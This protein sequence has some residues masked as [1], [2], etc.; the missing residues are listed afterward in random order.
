MALPRYLETQITKLGVNVKL[1]REFDAAVIE[2]DKPD[3]VILATGGRHEVAEI[4]GINSPNVID[5]AELHRK[6]K[7]Y[8]KLVKPY[9]LRWMT[10]YWMPIGKRVVIIGIGKQGLELGVFLVKR[11][12]KVTFVDTVEPFAGIRKSLMDKLLL[13]W[14]RKKEVPLITSVRSLEIT[15]QGIN[16]VTK[17]GEK[18][19]IEA[20]SIIPT[21]PLK[22]NTDLL[23]SLEG[24]VPEIYAV[25]D[26]N[27]AGLIAD[28]I[29]SS[30]RIARKL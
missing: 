28:A 1:G 10:K 2:Q 27:E 14:F 26:C 30:W 16:L 22:S 4:P 5:S 17:E 24:K 29:G 23:K 8:L 18:R 12:R 25:G 20:D 11:H 21:L 3:V 6:L 13:A 15:N 19:T 7:G 9:T